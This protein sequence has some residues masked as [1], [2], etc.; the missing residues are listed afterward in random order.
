MASLA[1]RTTLLRRTCS[2]WP[3]PVAVS[4]GVLAPHRCFSAASSKV[5]KALSAE[6]GHEESNYQQA[7]EIKKFLQSSDFKLEQEEGNVNMALVRNVGDKEVRIEFQL[8]SPF[9]PETE[10]MG[11]A[12]SAADMESTDFSVTIENKSG[13]GMTFYCSTQSGEDHRFIIGNVASF[14]TAEMKDAVSAYN[15]PDF[16]DLDDKLQE[17]LDEYLAEVGLDDEVCNAIDA[18][19]LDKE[20]REY[21]TWLKGMKSFIES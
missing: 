10:A 17:S 16:E 19:A 6:I 3:R 8:T 7:P 14:T 11:E 20:Q 5:S 4:L 21:M 12:G 13:A 2:L 9:D 1:L 18:L 15:G